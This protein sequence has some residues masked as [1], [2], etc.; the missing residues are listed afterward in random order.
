MPFVI[1][2]NSNTK[3]LER[4]MDDLQKKQLTFGT[5]LALNK[6]ALLLQECI[7][8][9]IP[10]I[11]NNSR[12]W[13]E[14][15]QRTGIRVKFASK[16]KRSSVVYTKAHFVNIQEKGSTRKPYF[17]KMIAVPTNNLPKKLRAS[18]ALR[19]EKS[20]KNIFKLGRSIYRRLGGGRLQRLYGL[21]PKANIKARFGF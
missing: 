16:Y 21:T 19:K 18:N 9:A 13:W 6:I 12:N 15:K 20:N 17:G 1:D 8:K 3:H 14:R 7:C 11:F 10:H 5:S 2:I 4:Y